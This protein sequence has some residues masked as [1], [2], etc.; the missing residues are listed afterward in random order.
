MPVPQLHQKSS[1]TPKNIHSNIIIMPTAYKGQLS[2]SSLTTK[3]HTD[4]STTN[5]LPPL[6]Q[7][8]TQITQ[9]STTHHHKTRIV[10]AGSTDSPLLDGGL[11]YVHQKPHA[12]HS[13]HT[14]TPPQPT[15]NRQSRG[16]TKQHRPSTFGVQ[17]T[18]RPTPP[19]TL[20]PVIAN[21]SHRRERSQNLPRSRQRRKQRKGRPP[22]RV[23][24]RQASPTT[25]RGCRKQQQ[26]PRQL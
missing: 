14:T 8:C 24:P 20:T 21:R 6:R 17:F 23:L 25:H 4:H 5:H 10:T 15:T 7:N 3:P 13:T 12:E 9:Q 22:K 11:V 18:R 26:S 1:K 2:D 16:N 19:T